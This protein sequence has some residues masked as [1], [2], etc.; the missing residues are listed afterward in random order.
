MPKQE[1]QKQKLLVLKEFFERETDEAHPA[2][3]PEIL[4]YLAARDIPAERKSIYSDIE[5]L[6]DFGLDLCLRRGRGG[7]YYLASRAFELPELKLLVDA[8]QSSRFLTDRKSMALIGKLSALASRHDAARLQRQVVVSGRVKTMNESIYYNVDRI[9]DAILNNSQIRFGYFDWDLG[10]ARR[11]RPGPYVA[12]PYALCWDHENYYLIAHSARH[13]LTHYRVDKMTRI[14]ETGT[15]RV[16]TEETAKLDL[17]A[18]LKKTF[19]M[20]GGQEMTVRLRFPRRLAGV[21]YDRFGHDAMLIP[22]G[23]DHFTFTAA[24]VD[25][26]LFYGWLAGFGGQAELLSPPAARQ[27]FR[28]MLEDALALYAV[29]DA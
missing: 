23:E 25:S 27:E 26:P 21:I 3:M 19:G 6:R 5:T 16:Q 7:G 14:Q 17:A 9:H 8:V 15:P 10:G 12:S 28:A 18:Y 22:D 1:R 20:F 4:A 24:V 13:G 2:S 29:D 11:A